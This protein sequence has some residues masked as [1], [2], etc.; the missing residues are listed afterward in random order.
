MFTSAIFYILYFG[1]YSSSD[2]C[3]VGVGMNITVNVIGQET[4]KL[5]H[6]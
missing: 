1:L 3:K 5:Q 4:E 6:N 2:W